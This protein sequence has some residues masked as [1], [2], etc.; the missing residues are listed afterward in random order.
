M[1]VSQPECRSAFS[2]A[3]GIYVRGFDSLDVRNGRI[4]PLTALIGETWFMLIR[5]Q[6]L[7]PSLSFSKDGEQPYEV[8]YSI[9]VLW[10][11]TNVPEDR[12]L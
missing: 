7:P 11:A 1:T 3:E 6:S 9:V 8:N 5:C 12:S 4:D 2:V 10:E